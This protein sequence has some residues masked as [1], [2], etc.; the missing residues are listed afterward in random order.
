MRD[1]FIVYADFE[2]INQPK[3]E[4]NHVSQQDPC[5]FAYKVV[6][7]DPHFTKPTITYVSKDASKTFLE[8]MMEEYKQIMHLL[9][10]VQPLVLTDKEEKCFQ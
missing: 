10:N 6:C 2:C 8:C 1:P 5:A 3:I 7:Q 9:N 4:G